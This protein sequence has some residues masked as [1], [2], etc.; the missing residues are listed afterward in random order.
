MRNGAPCSH[1]G[2]TSAVLLLSPSP[3]SAVLL[4]PS[5]LSSSSSTSGLSQCIHCLLRCL[6]FSVF[7]RTF[8]IR[9]RRSAGGVSHLILSG[10]VISV[11]GGWSLGLLKQRQTN[12]LKLMQLL[13]L[14][15]SHDNTKICFIYWQLTKQCCSKHVTRSMVTQTVQE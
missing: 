9:L 12:G 5:S 14:F 6:A 8:S 10:L 3:T 15:V 7:S 13:W 11:V 1:L 4:C 2:S